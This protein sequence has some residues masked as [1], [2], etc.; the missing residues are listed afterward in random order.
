MHGPG[1]HLAG[2]VEP[3]AGLEL[4]LERSVGLRIQVVDQLAL[5]V[6]LLFFKGPLFKRL[7]VM[8][9]LL[10]SILIIPMHMIS[11]DTPAFVNK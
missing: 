8:L 9:P 1:R 3:L 10:L 11:T 7:L 2:E 5:L 6:E 4:V